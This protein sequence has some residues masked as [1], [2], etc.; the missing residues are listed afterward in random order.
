MALDLFL[1]NYTTITTTK[2]YPTNLQTLWVYYSLINLVLSSPSISL[3]LPIPFL[4]GFQIVWSNLLTS[5][6]VGLLWTYLNHLK[7]CFTSFFNDRSHS[8]P[9]L[10]MIIPNLIFFC[11]VTHSSQHPHFSNPHFIFMLSLH[12]QHSLPYNTTGL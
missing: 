2:P 7:Q 4:F 8:N 1:Y 11:M 5:A 6:S 9:F 10:Y 12:S 3:G